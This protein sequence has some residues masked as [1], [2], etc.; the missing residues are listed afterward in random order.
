MISANHRAVIGYAI[1]ALIL[2]LILNAA[3]I[4]Q[5]LS[6][7]HPGERACWPS[8]VTQGADHANR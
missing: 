1:F 7:A 8:F 2:A 3:A 6:P 4:Y 5:R